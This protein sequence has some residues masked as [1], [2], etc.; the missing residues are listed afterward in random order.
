MALMK[1]KV[2]GQ[3]DNLQMVGLERKKKYPDQDIL[4]PKEELQENDQ[5]FFYSYKGQGK[6]T[7]IMHD[8][9]SVGAFQRIFGYNSNPNYVELF[10]WLASL[11]LGLTFWR[12]FYA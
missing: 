11:L 12:R 7:H 9:G 8:S 5:P 4:K 2:I 3:I 10:A 6:Y 1:L